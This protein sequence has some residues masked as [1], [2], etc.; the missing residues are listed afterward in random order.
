MSLR[1]LVIDN[2]DS[3]TY[4]LVQL[5]AELGAEVEVFRNDAI[6]A[7]G[8][9]ERDPDGVVLSPG[10]CTPAEA[11]CSVDVVR[12]LDPRRPLLGVCLGHQAIAAALGAR[13]VRGP[14][15]V[16]G[17]AWPIYHDGTGLLAGLPSPLEA[18]RYHSLVVEPGSLPPD[19]QV[20]AWTEDG[21]IMGLRHRHRP[22]YGLQFHPESV[23]TPQ[24]RHIL[25]R[26]LA[27]ARK[28]REVRRGHGATD[29]TA[30]AEASEV[31]EQAE[32]ATDGRV[33]PHGLRRGLE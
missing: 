25:A 7:A 9:E 5:L 22:V 17:M 19:L 23:L 32:A 8:V 18:G 21:L 20:C 11:G 15:P 29:A 16:H 3:F 33:L 27:I 1:V 26:F 30:V 10:P 28:M 13:V 12:Q 4:N 2:Y 31:V 24:G 14:E 6:D